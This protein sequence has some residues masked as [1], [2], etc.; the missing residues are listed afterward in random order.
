MVNPFKILFLTLISSL[1]FHNVSGQKYSWKYYSV[2]DGLPQ[3]QVYAIYQDSKGYIWI[4]TKGGLSKF[5]GIEFKNYT[6]RDGLSFDFVTRIQEDDDGGIYVGTVEGTNYLKNNQIEVL[7][8]LDDPLARFQF[9]QNDGT[10]WLLSG[11]KG[12]SC[13]K[14]GERIEAHEILSST[15]SNDRV[16]R[17]S[18]DKKNNNILVTKQSGESLLWNGEKIV[19]I[20]DD[21]KKVY[22]AFDQK[23][24]IYGY[25]SDSIYWY[26]NGKNEALLSRKDYII[27]N[28][29][30][31]NDIYLSDRLSNSKLF[32]FNGSD[33]TQFHQPFNMILQVLMDDENILWVGTESG[34]WR[35]QSRGFENFMSDP[36]KNF[37]AWQVTED[38]SGN[39]LFGSFLHGLVMY[40]GKTF[41]K[42][43]IDHMFRSNG[44]QFFYS[45]HHVDKNGDVYLGN[46][47]G[48][49]RYDG[50]DYSWFYRH[51]PNDAILYIYEDL[52]TNRLFCTSSQHGLIEIDRKGKVYEHSD[53][54][55]REHTGLETSVLR[56]K[57]GRIWLSGKQ[58]ISIKDNGRW[59]HLPSSEDNI[60]IG[61]ISMLRDPRDNIWLGSNHGLYFYNYES[62]VQIGEDVFDQQIGVL[63][64]TNDEELLIGSIKGIGLLDLKRFYENGDDKIRYF[65]VNNGFLGTECKHNSSF[66]D[67]NGN[68]WICTSDRVVKVIPDELKSNPFPPRVYLESIG[69]VSENGG[70]IKSIDQQDNGV[71][72]FD[73]HQEEIRI[74]YHG[75]NHTAPNGVRYQTMLEGYDQSWTS[76]SGERYRTFTNL[77]HGQYIF[78]V[79][80]FNNDGV[81]SDIKHIN[82]KILPAWYELPSLRYGGLISIILLAALFG[83]L[84]SDRLRKRRLSAEQNEKI[85]AKLQFKALRSLIDPHFTFNAINSIA[86]M[87]YREDRDEAYKY[88]TKF[89]KLIRSAFDTS[90]KT[91]RSIKEELSFVTNYL[92]IE[93]MRFKDRFDYTIELDKR[94]NHEWK[95]PK[96]IIQIYVENSIKHGLIEKTSGGLIKIN[97]D[98]ESETLGI[99]IEDNGVGRKNSIEHNSRNTLGR[100]TNMMKDYFKLLNKFNESK[101]TT[102]TIDLAD[103]NGNPLGTRVEVKIPLNYKYNL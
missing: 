38:K 1:L 58:G 33:I 93:K 30:S 39:Y 16:I 48:I 13:Y 2:T 45:S 101:I 83:F 91:T 81:E 89:S 69:P 18:Y 65:D 40:D 82:I 59:E 54:K 103:A 62:L 63:D 23:G 92:D 14:N 9:I 7:E 5:D 12:L 52:L 76:L 37:Y 79:K 25:D 6:S 28:V 46:A 102:T 71:Y 10:I 85:I 88:F 56:D 44:Y 87:V 98:M 24:D 11:T 47:S 32:H 100:G 36:D 57:H 94:I 95:I 90:D 4:G 22:L 75:V 3:T 96:M 51:N 68:I 50:Y 84:Y 15:E 77:S 61:A 29:I 73:A 72:Q 42:V 26:K 60:P 55:L 78:K 19:R 80:A 74:K 70:E 27:R 53:R 34:L 67:R 49:I 35:L 8:W 43:P 86:S 97:V 66:K 31:K 41:N 64:I 17:I 20:F 21:K 99:A